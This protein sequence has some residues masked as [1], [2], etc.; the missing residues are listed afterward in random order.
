MPILKVLL[1]YTLGDKE[2]L[3]QWSGILIIALFLGMLAV[4]S[5]D[6]IV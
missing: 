3:G 2:T 4:L 1:Y 5:S 6:N